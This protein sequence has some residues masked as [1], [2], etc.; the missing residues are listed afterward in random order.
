[1]ITRIFRDVATLLDD[2]FLKMYCDTIRERAASRRGTTHV[3][4]TDNHGNVAAMTVSN[5][6]G[7]GH[8]IPGTDIMM[9]NMLG[10]E[11]LNPGGFHRW[12]A[13][14][15]MSSMMAPTVAHLPDGRVIAT[16]SGGIKPNPHGDF[17][18]TD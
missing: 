16:G 9:N 18:S 8:I 6:E 10:E 3:N 5:G 17:A 4:V 15:R 12:H 1:M 13:N 14:Q 11:D 7:C 2:D